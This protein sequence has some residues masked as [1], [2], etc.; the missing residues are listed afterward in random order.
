VWEE[1]I[2]ASKIS[3]SSLSFLVSEFGRTRA[4]DGKEEG[5][6]EEERGGLALN[7]E[8]KRRLLRFEAFVFV[9]FIIKKRFGRSM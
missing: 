7:G 5:V 3:K 6:K 4:D 8:G 1:R 2:G 9:F